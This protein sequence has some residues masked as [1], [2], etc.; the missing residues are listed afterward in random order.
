MA[1]DGLQPADGDLLRLLV[2]EYDGESTTSELRRRCGYDS[3]ESIKYRIRKLR[4]VGLARMWDRGD[5]RDG[6]PLAKGVEATHLGIDAVRD[7]EVPGDGM[8]YEQAGI[9]ERLLD[10]ES[11]IERLDLI[12]DALQRELA[13]E[14][15]IV[16]GEASIVDDE[17]EEAWEGLDLR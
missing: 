10:L 11:E 13:V 12:V 14:V 4:D 16:D 5:D 9:D 3:T 1:F 17:A 6:A 8:T 2:E 7:G 15:E